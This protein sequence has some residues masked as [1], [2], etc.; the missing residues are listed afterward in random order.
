M[1]KRTVSNAATAAEER[2]SSVLFFRIGEPFDDES[3]CGRNVC[4]CADT[5]RDEFIKS[6]YILAWRILRRRTSEGEGE[7]WGT[8]LQML[9]G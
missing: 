6:E 5:W 7:K 2:D 3:E 1:L 4:S 8:Y 9:G